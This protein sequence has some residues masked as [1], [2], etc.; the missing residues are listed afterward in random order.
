[1]AY[2]IPGTNGYLIGFGT[3]RASGTISAE[4]G[5]AGVSPSLTPPMFDT[6]A[7]LVT[8]GVGYAQWIGR[9]P[10]RI[11]SITNC[12]VNLSTAA[13]G[14]G[15]AELALASGTLSAFASSIDL[16]V[17]A[18]AD[19]D[20][21]AKAGGTRVISKTISGVNFAPGDDIWMI[22]AS[23]HSVTQTTTRYNNGPDLKGYSRTR[24]A[25]Q[26]SLNIGSA[27]AFTRSA[28]LGV[29]VAVPQMAADII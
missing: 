5:V 17:Q 18:Y 28:A 4:G 14:T 27:L 12:Y 10:K 1:M 29:A 8:A 2:V 3:I 13:S 19:I 26:P 21:E 9:A 20:T 23:S 24:A 11:T 16:T 22:F 15:W 7:L 6:S 25:F